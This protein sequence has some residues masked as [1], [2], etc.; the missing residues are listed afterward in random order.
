LRPWVDA[1]KYM[2]SARGPLSSNRRR[3]SA[4]RRER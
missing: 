2:T 3:A 4:A 1:D